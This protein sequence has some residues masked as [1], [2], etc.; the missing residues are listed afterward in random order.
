MWAPQGGFPSLQGVDIHEGHLSAVSVGLQQQRGQAFQRD[1]APRTAMLPG[2]RYE[3]RPWTA[4]GDRVQRESSYGA[5]TGTWAT[6]QHSNMRQMQ[7]L[8]YREHNLSRMLAQENVQGLYLGSSGTEFREGQQLPPGR[9]Q[10][11]GD[12]G[13]CSWPGT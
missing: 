7:F 10:L 12:R 13:E 9:C 5:G 4:S 11:K 2:V 8:R 6:A 1:R 3:G